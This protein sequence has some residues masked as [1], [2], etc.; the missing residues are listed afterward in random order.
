MI[1]HLPGLLAGMFIAAV[2]LLFRRRKSIAPK[3]LKSVGIVTNKIKDEKIEAA[4]DAHKDAHA[5]AVQSALEIHGASLDVLADMA[6]HEFG[7]D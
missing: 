1:E 6:N 3:I 7:S 2:A 4:Q 5:E